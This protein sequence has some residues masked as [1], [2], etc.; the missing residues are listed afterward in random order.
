LGFVLRTWNLDAISLA[1]VRI[2]SSILRDENSVLTVSSLID[3]YYDIKDVCLS[4]PVILSKNCVFKHIYIKLDETESP[5]Y[6]VSAG[7]LKGMIENP[8][9]RRG[10]QSGKTGN[11]QTPGSAFIQ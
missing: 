5:G 10:E 6:R 3:E 7:S 11:P 2:V 8:D 1:L 9:I 4:I